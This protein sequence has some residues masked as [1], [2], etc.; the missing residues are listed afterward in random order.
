MGKNDLTDSQES[1]LEDTKFLAD[2]EKNCKTKTKEREERSKTRAEEIL[3]L[4]ETIK[5]LNSD[6]ALELFKKTL[7]SASASL[8]QVEVSTNAL[9]VRALAMINEMR[10][11][12]KPGRQ[13][14]DFIALALHG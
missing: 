2:L 8:V 6:D 11:H 14:L 10:Q 3:A 1:V 13:S 5:I 4:A 7:P 12:F 9:R